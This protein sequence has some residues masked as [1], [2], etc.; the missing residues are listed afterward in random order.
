MVINDL[1]VC[2][3]KKSLGVLEMR[4]YKSIGALGIR[5]RGPSENKAHYLDNTSSVLSRLHSYN[6]QNISC[7]KDQRL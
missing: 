5:R 2:T 1:W 3:T 7:Y 6:T 4:A